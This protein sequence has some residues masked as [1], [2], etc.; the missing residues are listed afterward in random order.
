MSIEKVP[1]KDGHV[2]R[3]RWRDENGRARSKVL[4]RKADAEA[5]EIEVKRAKRIGGLDDFTRK[6]PTLATFAELWW[7]R[8]AKPH[9][10]ARTLRNYAGVWDRHV[11]PYLGDQ[12][13]RRIDTDMLEG[14]THELREG[15]L[16]DPSIYRAQIVLQS[17]MRSAVEWGYIATNPVKALRKPRTKRKRIVRPLTDE[18]VEQLLRDTNKHGSVRDMLIISL[19]VGEG[20]RPQEVFALT[21][22]DVATDAGITV[23]KA[24]DYDGTVKSTK[25]EQHRV[26]PWFKSQNL[27][28]LYYDSERNKIMHGDETNS[29]ILST[30]GRPFTD[31]MWQS[32]HRDVWVKVRP[33]PDIRPY[34]L[35]HTFISN[36]IDEGHNIIQIAKWAGHSPT[37]TLEVYGHLFES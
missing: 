2:W 34:D 23:N 29:L 14:W 37:M 7:H 32:W 17:V 5:F 24:I 19:M 10:A 22:E 6:D 11:L 33:S 20:L 25:T 8:R 27:L 15:G 13:L 18:Q 9:L 35:R 26:V 30:R 16:G 1:R 36:L 28:G 3:V 31:G 21:H 12:R 4:G